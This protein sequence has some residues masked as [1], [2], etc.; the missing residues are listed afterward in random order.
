SNAVY[1]AP[2]GFANGMN[3]SILYGGVSLDALRGYSTGTTGTSPYVFATHAGQSLQQ[4]A[5]YAAQL[6]AVAQ[7]QQAV[8]FAAA[9]QQQQQQQQNLINS[10][11]AGYMLVRTANGGYALLGNPTGASTATMQPQ[12]QASLA[13]QQ[14]ISFNAAG[15]PTAATSRYPVAM[16]GGQSQQLVYQYAGQPTGQATPTQYIQVPANYVQQQLSTSPIMQAAASTGSQGF[17]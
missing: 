2:A 17:Y 1:S 12:A 10:I 3:G 5:L 7:Q 8:Q 9:Q 11:P 14:Y 15:Q 16:V 6:Q 13:Q 4:P